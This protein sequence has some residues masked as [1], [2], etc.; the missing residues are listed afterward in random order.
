MKNQI[1][2]V[3]KCESYNKEEVRKAIENGLNNIDFKFKAKKVLIK[4]N[5]L[6]P[7]KPEEAITTHPVVLEELC[8][9]LKKKKCKIFIGDSSGT[10]TDKALGVCGIRK[11]EKY[12]EI[13]NFEK[14]EK[15]GIKISE[16]FNVVRIPK[17]I[18]E[19][20]LIINVAK[21]KTHI[22]TDATLAVKNLYGL[23]PGNAKQYYHRILRKRES[24]VDFIIDLALK[25]KPGLNIIDGVV[26][27]EGNG[28]GASGQKTKAGVLIF[29]KNIFSIDLVAGKI[30]GFK[31]DE[32][33]INKRALERGIVKKNIVV[34]GSGKN[35]EKKFKRP[36]ATPFR[37]ALFLNSIFPKP[38]ISFNINRCKKCGLCKKNCPV[39]AI[40]L[41]PYP[42]CDNKKCI[43]CFCCV[44]I[45][46]EKA[47]ELKENF[48]RR[49]IKKLINLLRKLKKNKK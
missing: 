30:M 44:E 23:I 46:P 29:G 19:F 49:M 35:I 32:I 14:L 11:L 24:F 38:K 18:E 20:D 47:V 1:V 31:E 37:F 25:I 33:I 5:L 17:I 15:K 28:P 6:S 26:G 27:I 45:C 21:M 16:K 41:N 43:N 42:S 40:I 39:Q 8:K 48:A 12:A 13:L 3:E 22:L 7:S 10:N 2:A 36:L 34:V 4:P 9:I